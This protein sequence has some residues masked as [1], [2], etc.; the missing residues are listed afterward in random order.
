MMLIDNS[1]LS[2]L[3]HPIIYR[4]QDRDYLSIP[5]WEIDNIRSH[6][7]DMGCLMQHSNDYQPFAQR[8]SE[9]N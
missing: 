8:R 2:D 3:L 4:T 6:S 7:A 5:P 9:L 1:P